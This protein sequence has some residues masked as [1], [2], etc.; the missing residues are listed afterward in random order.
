MEPDDRPPHALRPPASSGVVEH[1]LPAHA[2]LSRYGGDQ[3]YA[4]CYVATVARRVTQ[5]EY[6]EAFYTTGLFKLERRILG[7]LAGRPSSDEQ[8]GELARAE[9]DRFS[10][11]TVEDRAAGQLLLADAVGGTRSWLMTEPAE[12]GGT[13][14]YFGSAVVP[15]RRGG[16]AKPRMGFLFHALLGFHKRYSRALLSAA[17]R[18]LGP[19]A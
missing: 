7:V 15:R 5:A 2:L 11:W 9:R 1:P 12:D 6:V 17:C 10:A 18:R 13:R 19:A 3:G 8:A 14:L 4:D 16:S